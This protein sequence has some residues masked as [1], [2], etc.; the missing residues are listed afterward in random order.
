[1]LGQL[2]K[3]AWEERRIRYDKLRRASPS[4]Q[5]GNGYCCHS[6]DLPKVACMNDMLLEM[7]FLNVTT[8]LTCAM[9]YPTVYMLSKLVTFEYIHFSCIK[10]Y[11]YLNL[12]DL[13][14]VDWAE[15]GPSVERKLFSNECWWKYPLL[16]AHL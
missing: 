9:D 2:W 15:N 13:G 4:S 12:N 11:S 1:M 7:Q 5:T 6:S 8:L 10:L 3:L 16:T 14:P